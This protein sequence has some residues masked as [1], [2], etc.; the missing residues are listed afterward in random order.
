MYVL[1]LQWDIVALQ[2]CVCSCPLRSP[3]ASAFVIL[4]CSVG[5]LS[6][7]S[8]SAVLCTHPAQATKVSLTPVYGIAPV[9]WGCLLFCGWPSL[10]YVLR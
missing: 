3:A 9:L 1:H 6:L 10:P 8:P 4:P 2:V 7:A 5:R